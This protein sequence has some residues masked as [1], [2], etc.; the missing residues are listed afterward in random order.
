M[1]ALNIIFP[2]QILRGA[3]VINRLGGSVRRVSKRARSLA[4]MPGWQ[5]WTH[6][7]AINWRP[8]R[9]TL[10]GMEWFGGVCSEENIQRPPTVS[11]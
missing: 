2:A 11:R 6:R 9:S 3:G 5:R 8:L 10:V 1:Q 7:F 4:G